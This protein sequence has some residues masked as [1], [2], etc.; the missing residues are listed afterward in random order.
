VV[1]G[2]ATLPAN[3]NLEGDNEM[4]RS[5]IVPIAM[6][7]VFAAGIASSSL[8]FAESKEAGEHKEIT[9]VMNAKTSLTQAIAAA[10][11]QIGGK[12]I[13]AAL[14]DRKG[15]TA[16]EVEIASGSKLQ[17]VFVDLETGKI[18]KTIAAN[19]DDR[20]DNDHDED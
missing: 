6:A 19:S 1:L 5:K 2:L 18:V 11:Q 17:K 3:P 8:A 20:K 7:A 16:Y 13:S 4:F 14:E 10:E 15:V 9:A 12:A